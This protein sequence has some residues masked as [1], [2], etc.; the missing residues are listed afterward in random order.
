VADALGSGQAKQA[1]QS[2]DPQTAQQVS[3]AMK[4]AFV[5]G[6]SGSLKLSTAVAATGAVL[7]FALVES[8]VGKRAPAPAAEPVVEPAGA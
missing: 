3:A 8:K 4:D 7:A 6:L 2:L 5:H 1:V